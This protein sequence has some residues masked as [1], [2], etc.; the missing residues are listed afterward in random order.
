MEFPSTKLMPLAIRRATSMSKTLAE[1]L[2]ANES[3]S[4]SCSS[5]A[6]FHSTK[7]DVRT[8]ADRLGPIMV[9]ARRPGAEGRKQ[10]P[11]F[12]TCMPDYTAEMQRR[13]AE[14]WRESRGFRQS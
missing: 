8:R 7:L 11:L 2:A 14:R 10:G 6:C 12:F 5:P 13:I 4:V 3:L 9:H 1:V